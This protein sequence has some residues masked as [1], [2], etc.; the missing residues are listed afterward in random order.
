MPLGLVRLSPDTITP[1]KTSGYRSSDPIIHFSHTHVAGTGGMSRYGNIGVVPFTGSPRLR[2]A[3]FERV[4]ERA[5]CAYY[6]VT[7]ADSGVRCEL[8]TTARVGVHRYTFPTS[9][10]A[11]LLFDV[12]AVIQPRFGGYQNDPN[13]WPPHSTGG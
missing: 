13:G 7:T 2:V 3:P 1:H 12:G 11:H 9:W 10:A 8:T 4:D 5:A 6:A